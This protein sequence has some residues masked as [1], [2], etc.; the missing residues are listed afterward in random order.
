MG[1]CEVTGDKRDCKSCEQPHWYYND[2]QMTCLPCDCQNMTV[3]IKKICN[4]LDFNSDICKTEEPK[5]VPTTPAD[6]DSFQDEEGKVWEDKYTI[7]IVGF[8]VVGVL[9]LYLC[10]V[11]S[12]T[13]QLKREHP[14]LSIC[15]RAWICPI[16][17]F[18]KATSGRP[19]SYTTDDGHSQNGNGK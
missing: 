13:K 2:T 17:C 6:V 10:C 9:A 1:K 11:R 14:Q 16:F 15:N 18:K 19:P 3:Q 5:T 7:I 12:R 4:S 8:V